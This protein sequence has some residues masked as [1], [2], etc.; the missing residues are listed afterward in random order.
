MDQL[1][2][3]GCNW[4]VGTSTKGVGPTKTVHQVFCNK[5]CA[6]GMTLCPKHILFRDDEALEPLRRW[7]AT[8]ATRKYRKERLAALAASPLATH[9]PKFD[10]K[11]KDMGGMDATEEDNKRPK[12]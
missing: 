1:F 8:L 3:N 9:N 4:V 10:T 5:L 7:Q 2:S 6:G 11:P 12:T